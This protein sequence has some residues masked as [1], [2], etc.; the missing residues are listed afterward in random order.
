MDAADAKGAGSAPARF[1]KKALST[2]QAADEHL[3]QLK[4]QVGSTQ[5]RLRRDFQQAVASRLPG[6]KQRS[7]RLG[8][9]FASLHAPGDSASSPSSSLR[10]DDALLCASR[11]ESRPSGK[12]SGSL[13][14]PRG[15]RAKGDDQP[16]KENT[17]YASFCIVGMLW[18]VSCVR[19]VPVTPHL[20]TDQV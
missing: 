9:A 18:G 7:L 13:W 11:V 16:T 10:E 3:N 5:E 6:A 8:P 12:V 2:L 4:A 14:G 20:L 1:L 17:P 15:A 19:S